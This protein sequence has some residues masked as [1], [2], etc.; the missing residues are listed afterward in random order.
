MEGCRATAKACTARGQE[1]PE[2]GH[3]NK[4]QI[5]NTEMFRRARGL[6]RH[7][8]HDDEHLPVEVRNAPPEHVWSVRFGF[9]QA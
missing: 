8:G 2:A 9:R 6:K 1:L 4:V 5:R 3:G 7:R